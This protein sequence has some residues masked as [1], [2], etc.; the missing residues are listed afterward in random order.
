MVLCRCTLRYHT[1]EVPTTGKTT[2]VS[3]QRIKHTDW[4]I[5]HFQDSFFTVSLLTFHVVYK[6]PSITSLAAFHIP[7]NPPEKS[8]I[9]TLDRLQNP[10]S[11]LIFP[12]STQSP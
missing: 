10:Y 2:I 7:Y 3:N 8:G 12:K 4:S 9:A 1:L 6:K 5:H 11:A